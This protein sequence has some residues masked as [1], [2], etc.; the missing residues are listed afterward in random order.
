MKFFEEPKVEILDVAVEDV[1]TVSPDNN[2]EGSAGD[3][4]G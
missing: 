1:I 3:W 4:E 2:D